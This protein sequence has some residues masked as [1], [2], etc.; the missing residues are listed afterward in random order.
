MTAWD[1]VT[2]GLQHGGYP[3]W[4]AALLAAEGNAGRDHV[5]VFATFDL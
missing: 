3:A 4:E 1:H 2:D 5:P